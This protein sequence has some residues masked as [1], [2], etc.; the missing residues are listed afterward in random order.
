M[1]KYGKIVLIIVLAFTLVFSLFACKTGAYWRGQGDDTRKQDADIPTVNGSEK[2]IVFAA[3]DS[4]GNLIASGS[5]T[6]T[7]AYAVV[8]YTG[9]RCWNHQHP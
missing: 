2:Y 3:L 8:G 7:A 5:S 4:S 6:E 9:L 1:R